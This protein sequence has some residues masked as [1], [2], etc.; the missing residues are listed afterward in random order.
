[1]NSPSF[2]AVH[3]QPVLT[4]LTCRINPVV[5]ED[6]SELRAYRHVPFRPIGTTPV[7]LG[8]IQPLA[9]RRFTLEDDEA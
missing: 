9:V 6:L 3:E 1:M 8:P 4:E 5:V 2:T 7:R